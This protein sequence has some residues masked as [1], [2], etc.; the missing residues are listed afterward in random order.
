VSVEKLMTVSMLSKFPYPT[1]FV[2]KNKL[3]INKS[4]NMAKR[5]FT[6][7]LPTIFLDIKPI[8]IPLHILFYTGNNVKTPISSDKNLRL[9]QASPKG[10]LG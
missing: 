4:V 5:P 8:T 9:T 2:E 10:I 1:T 3:E 7:I 6:T